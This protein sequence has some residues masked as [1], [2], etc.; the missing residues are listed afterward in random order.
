M[1]ASN[2]AFKYRVS[3]L[4]CSITHHNISSLFDSRERLN[5]YLL[6]INRLIC[7]GSTSIK[8]KMYDQCNIYWTISLNFSIMWDI[9]FYLFP[10]YLIISVWCNTLMHLPYFFFANSLLKF[11]S[12]SVKCLISHND[13][14]YHTILGQSP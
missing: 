6:H 10:W 2:V 11:N 13:H 7:T 12:G 5:V 9:L 3:I 8:S 4:Q 1:G 14:L